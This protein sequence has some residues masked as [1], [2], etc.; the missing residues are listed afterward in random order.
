MNID[1]LF[2][3]EFYEGEVVCDEWVDAH[4]TIVRVKDV[5]ALPCDLEIPARIDD[6]YYVTEI[7][8]GAFKGLC[9]LRSVVIPDIVTEIGE[10]A[11]EDCKDLV[12]VTLGQG[13]EYIYKHAFYGCAALSDVHIRNIGAYCRI[14]FSDRYASPISSAKR[15]FVGDAPLGERLEIPAE[16]AASRLTVDRIADHAFCGLRIKTLVFA[17]GVEEMRIKPDAFADCDEL[18]HIELPDSLKSLDPTGLAACKNIKYNEYGG[19]RYLG[20]AS[21]PYKALVRADLNTQ[22]LAMHRDTEIICRGA[23]DGCARLRRLCVSERLK[24]IDGRAFDGCG[25]TVAVVLP[26]V[27]PEIDLRKLG[28]HTK[29]LC[30]EYN[31]L[32][33]LGSAEN[34]Y[35]MV[36]GYAQKART[37]ELHPDTEII[38]AGA[39]ENN[40]ELERF[41]ASDKV[42]QINAGAFDGC[43]S[44]K[45]I[46]LPSGFKRMAASF[47]S[48]IKVA[49]VHCPDIA[50]W[51]GI[52]FDRSLCKGFDRSFEL[53]L[54]GALA[55]NVIIPDG[56]DKI[57]A[58]AFCQCGSI[59]HVTLSKSVRCIHHDA[60]YKCG[61]LESV[62]ITDGTK[63]IGS[64]AFRYCDSLKAVATAAATVG[65]MAFADCAALESVRFTACEELYAEVFKNS[66]ALRRVEIAGSAKEIN[67]SAFENCV[68]LRTVR[69]PASL[70]YIGYEAFKG[71]RALEDIEFPDSVRIIKPQAFRDCLSLKAVKLTAVDE[72]GQEAFEH[73]IALESV[74]I[75]GN[76]KYLA[77]EIFRECTRLTYVRIPSCVEYIG[78]DA[79]RDC[80][81]LR[82]I[83]LPASLKN[84][85]NRAFANCGVESVVIPDGAEYIGGQAFWNCWRLKRVAIPDSVVKVGRDIFVQCDDALEIIASDRVKALLDAPNAY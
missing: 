12:S 57:Q 24:Y 76:I 33:Y 34:P 71:C 73:C 35:K 23:F 84:I 4:C 53:Y 17:D 31:G 67:D 32:E 68:A 74:S 54:G 1:E 11:F 30:T 48:H 72:I 70:E 52:T 41:V 20:S 65:R 21:D 26:D 13:I 75:A 46:F 37:Y 27:A 51:C 19:A 3:C 28:A 50:D 85:V 5:A 55:Q 58:Y 81:S 69:L 63:H 82:E 78:G 79:F 44:L 2:E 83:E 43:I 47:D 18:T 15:V 36:V 61:A 59:K 80:G 25:A 10:S 14:Y 29:P 16:V 60:F 42:A 22:E 40:T 45:S 38:G 49:E 77:Q 6:E 39:F 8:G 64:Y 62:S 56:V 66:K 9:G 7:G